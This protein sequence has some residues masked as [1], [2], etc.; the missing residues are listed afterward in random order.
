MTY[1]VILIFKTSKYNVFHHI[2]QVD[3]WLTA[4]QSYTKLESD[5]S[6]PNGSIEM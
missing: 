6:V 3:S 4:L 1:I 2:F 5:R